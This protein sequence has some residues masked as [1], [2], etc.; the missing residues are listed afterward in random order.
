MSP[1][2]SQTVAVH[3][4]T[5]RLLPL[6]GRGVDALLW[7][8]RP[9]VLTWAAAEP[10]ATRWLVRAQDLSALEEL[11][12][13]LEPGDERVLSELA[14]DVL[15][16]L[17][18]GAYDLELSEAPDVKE[19]R[20]ATSPDAPEAGHVLTWA[21]LHA[22]GTDD[23]PP[24]VGTVPRDAIDEEAI[25]QATEQIVAGERP[26]AIVLGL[27]APGIVLAGHAAVAAWGRMGLPPVLLRIDPVEPEYLDDD[28]ADALL[29]RAFEHVGRLAR[30]HRARQRNQARRQRDA[31]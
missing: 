23:A 17:P 30:A 4:G 31:G 1:S 22:L 5:G 20:W 13:V 9:A 19:A 12:P 14:R 18:D 6:A 10:G 7:D 27:G 16:W 29:A 11:A 8:T 2:R 21:G 28:D 26:C 25:F 15:A 3:G 24:L